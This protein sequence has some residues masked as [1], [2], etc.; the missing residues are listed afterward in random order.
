[1]GKYKKNFKNTKYAEMIPEIPKNFAIAVDTEKDETT[2]TMY[3]EIG[4][5]WWGD[6]ITATDVDVALRGI[7]TSNIVVRLNSPGGDAFDGVA[8]YNRLKDHDAKIKIIVDGWACSAASLIMMAGDEIIVNTGGMVMIH[9]AS[10][11]TRGTKTD[12]QK[13]VDMMGKLDNNILDIYMTKAIVERDEIKQ[14][15]ENETWFTADEAVAVGLATGTATVVE[16]KGGNA[17]NKH[18]SESFKNSV[19]A[20]FTK[21]T[22]I[23]QSTQTNNILNKFKRN[24]NE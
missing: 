11:W 6:C 17:Q 3:G 4:D 12:L 1:M 18:D 5:S 2:L 23:D 10:V 8:I 24:S 19:L 14:F 16:D 22:D 21:G 13:T 7:K 20:R 9:E 15:I